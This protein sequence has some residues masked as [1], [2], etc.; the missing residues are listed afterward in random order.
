MLIIILAALG[1]LTSLFL[2][3]VLITTPKLKI[4]YRLFSEIRDVLK[5]ARSDTSVFKAIVMSVLGFGFWCATFLAQFPAYGRD[6]LGVDENV[7]TFF[8]FSFSLGV[9]LGSLFIALLLKGGLSTRFTP[10][11]VIGIFIFGHGSLFCLIGFLKVLENPS[12][13]CLL[14]SLFLKG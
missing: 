12:S 2:K 13:L 1:F 9:G 3:K 8:L 7:V 5:Q 10:F 14:F 4:S 6:V 11:A